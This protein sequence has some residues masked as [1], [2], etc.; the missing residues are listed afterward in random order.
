MYHRGDGPL[1][2]LC[3]G[4]KSHRVHQ[5]GRVYVLCLNL[6]DMPT[7]IL[8]MN[9]KE[10]TAMAVENYAIVLRFGAMIQPMT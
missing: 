3:D 5:K 7:K 6:L 10:L 9:L 4:C 8:V 2:G 1:Q